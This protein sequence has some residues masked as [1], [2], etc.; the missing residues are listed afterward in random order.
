MSDPERIPDTTVSSTL[1]VSATVEVDLTGS[2]KVTLIALLPRLSTFSTTGN[3]ESTG[4]NSTSFALTAAA[5]ASEPFTLL[6]DKVYFSWFRREVL[7]V[8]MTVFLSDC[9]PADFNATT[10]PYSSFRV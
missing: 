3:A 9:K 2:E 8:R 10:A 5:V 1:K 4:V 6:T 7:T